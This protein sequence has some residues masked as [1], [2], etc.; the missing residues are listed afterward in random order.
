MYKTILETA[1]QFNFEPE[2]KN[3]EKLKKYTG[4][5]VV[6]MGG[7]ALAT[8]LV[9][10]ILPQLDIVSHKN[11]GLPNLLKSDLKKRLIILCSYSGNTEEVIDAYQKA[12]QMGLDRAVITVGGK[13]LEMVKK[14]R[15]P[16]I[17]MI[18]LGIQPRTA[19]PLNLMSLLKILGQE[20]VLSEIKKLKDNF[21]IEKLE[22][23]GKEL[24]KKIKGRVPIIYTATE[25]EILGYIWKITFNETGKI[26]AFNNVVPELN[27]NE[28]NGFGVE[29]TT[30]KLSQNFYFIFLSDKDDFYKIKKKNGSNG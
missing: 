8:G 2:I 22:V 20:K 21:F 3:K 5:L 10:M 9:K 29:E 7:S 26:P 16:Y 11:Y 12:G 27:H 14:D 18:D 23:E 25:K 1:K 13:L 6:G 17:Q 19:L 30:V 15:V 24:A 28:M 4:Y